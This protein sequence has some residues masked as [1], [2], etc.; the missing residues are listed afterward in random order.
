M[1]NI[2]T[3]WRDNTMPPTNYIWMR[4]N[5]RNELLGVYEWLN[6]HWHRI[7]F[8]GSG[9]YYTKQEVDYLLQ[10]TEQEII[11]KLVEGEYEI[12]D[13]IIDDELSLESENAVQNKVITAELQNKIDRS[14]FNELIENIPGLS[15]IKYGTTEHWNSLEGYIPKEGEVI[16][17]SD[18]SI[19]VVDG[20]IVNIPAIKIG[21]GNAYVQDLAFINEELADTLWDHILNTTI[22]VTARDKIRWNN[23]LNVNDD[24]AVVQEV[25]ILNRN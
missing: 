22:H 8:D 3:I 9:D 18:H 6:G 11:R 14:E 16:I 10:W 17:Y 4:T 7:K 20:K 15:G 25:L 2:K 21:S 12:D 23:K 19:K 1:R 13:W 5:M 24:S